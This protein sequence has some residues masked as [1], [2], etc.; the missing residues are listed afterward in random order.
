MHL[1]HLHHWNHWK[2]DWLIVLAS[3]SCKARAVLREQCSK[4]SRKICE[5]ERGTVM[6]EFDR[7]TE[8]HDSFLAMLIASIGDNIQRSLYHMSAVQIGGSVSANTGR[9]SDL[10]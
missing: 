7:F 8:V 9:D 2:F 5:I 10:G 3:N 6:Q 4:M 1:F